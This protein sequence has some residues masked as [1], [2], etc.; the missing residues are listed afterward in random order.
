MTKEYT[1]TRKIF[2]HFRRRTMDQ[3]KIKRGIFVLI[4]VDYEQ[5]ICLKNLFSN[6]LISLLYTWS[7]CAK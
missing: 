5:T 7:P 3:T 4:E 1:E 2:T 6:K